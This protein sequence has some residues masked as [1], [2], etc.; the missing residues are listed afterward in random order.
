MVEDSIGLNNS[1]IPDECK[2]ENLFFE[3]VRVNIL[4]KFI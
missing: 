3:F 1:H 2:P 4:L